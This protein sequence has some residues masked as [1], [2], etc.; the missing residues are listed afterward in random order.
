ME[1]WYGTILALLLGGCAGSFVNAVIYRWPRGMSLL[2]PSRSFCPTCDHTIAWYD[3]VPV[4][5]YLRLGGR[6][7]H[8]RHPISLQY[9]L[10][11]LATA[12]VFVITLDAFFAARQRFGIGDMA[13]DWPM[14]V[15]H[16][17]LWAG[18]IALAVMDLEFYLVDIHITWAIC[19][20]GLLG[21][22]I[23]TPAGSKDW[24]RATP[25]QTLFTVAVTTGLTIGY[26]LF[27]RGR[28]ELDQE[29]TLEDEK[30]S[31]TPPEAV[32]PAKRQIGP[33]LIVAILLVVAYAVLVATMGAQRPLRHPQLLERRHLITQLAPERESDAG[34]IRLAAGLAL[35]FIG[36]VLA[37]SQPSPEA[38]EAIVTAIHEEAP[39]ARRNALSEMRLLLPATIL[40][41]ASL[42]LLASCWGPAVESRVGRLL[43][44]APWGHWRPFWGVATALAGWIIGGLIGWLTRVIG[45]LVFGKEAL[46]MGDVHIL[47]AAGA[48]AGW[49]VALMG[50]FMSAVLALLGLIIIHFRRQSRMLPFGPWLALGF[51]VACVYQDR[52]LLFF[53]V[54]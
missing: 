25:A 24:I 36:L 43:E 18:L 48:V 15:A 6:C 7:R 54:R 42:I 30:P 33:L 41:L 51:L 38:D 22:A 2:S 45:T 40:G 4:L 27:L 9:P 28:P 52:I 11:E 21:H 49:P 31:S 32:Q 1:I 17:G 5:S 10:V 29:E 19:L 23:W 14:L 34:A 13:D 39:L 46:G 3:N 20:V 44:W 47:A 53:Q 35:T 12:L 8:C 37:G 50:F 16:W 26:F